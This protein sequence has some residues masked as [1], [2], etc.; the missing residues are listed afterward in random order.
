MPSVCSKQT[1]W[2]RGRTAAAASGSW[3]LGPSH[4]AQPAPQHLAALNSFLTYIEGP[5]AYVQAANGGGMCAGYRPAY[6]KGVPGYRPADRDLGCCDIRPS[7]ECRCLRAG[8][9]QM[10]RSA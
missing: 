3:Q 4:G 6:A 1:H 7:K 10:R 2:L 9:G 5:V 8:H